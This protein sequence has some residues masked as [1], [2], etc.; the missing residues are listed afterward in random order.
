MSVAAITGFAVGGAIGATVTPH[1]AHRGLTQ[2][3]SK[4][5]FRPRLQWITAAAGA[6]AGTAAVEA[7][8][9]PGSWAGTPALLAWA[10]TLTAAAACD[11]LTQRVPT[12]LVRWGAAITTLFL[13]AGLSARQNWE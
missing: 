4:R 3:G 2:L 9:R 12:P 8:Y 1:L 5:L 7:A 6:A 13:V 10:C 11:A